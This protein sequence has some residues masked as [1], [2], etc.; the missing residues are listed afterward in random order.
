MATVARLG[1]DEFAVLLHQCPSAQALVIAEKMRSA[2]EAYAIDWEGQRFSVGA[3]IGLVQ[4]D[5]NFSGHDAV[6]E[7]ADAA[8]YAA[9]RAGRNRVSVHAAPSAAAAF[10]A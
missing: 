4:V 6:L 5:A 10:P 3:S 1:G 8:C 9:K 2:V 7:A